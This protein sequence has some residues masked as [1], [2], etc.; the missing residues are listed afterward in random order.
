MRR[1]LSSVAMLMLA[2]WSCPPADAATWDASVD[3]RTRYQSFLD[4]DFN[5]GTHDDRQ[6][7][8]NR[9]YLKATSDLG[10]GLSACLQMQAIFIRNHAPN[11]GGQDFTQADLLQAWL[12]YDMKLGDGRFALRLGRQQLVYGD[13]RLWGHLGWKDVAR[14]F[15]GIKGMYRA[16][17]LNLDLFAVHPADLS[18]MTP[19]PASPHGKALVTWE[20]R[21]LAGAYGTF[22][23]RKETGLDAYFINWRH[24]QRAA[25][26]KGRNIQTFGARAFA[27]WRGFDATVEAAFQRGTWKNG[28]SQ[29][30]SA[31]AAKAGYSLDFWDTR[32]GIEYDFSPG[33]DKTDPTTHRNFVFPFHTNHMHYGEMDF[34]SWANMKDFRIALRTSPVSGLTLT[35][36]V[37]FLFLDKARGD[38]LNVVGTGAVFPGSPGFVQTRAGTEIDLKAIYKTPRMPGLTLVAQ[39]A[40]F[41]PGAAVAERNGGRADPA[42]FITLFA[43]YVS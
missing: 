22:L 15:D 29:N 34:F 10:H 11:H 24:N 40:L 27:R 3:F 18:Q 14:T 42:R 32:I 19:S 35:G 20:N 30:A 23:I 31:F 8:D 41:K 21:T 43:R 9:L 16:G 38:W 13:Q 28:V 33:D 26:G 5:S 6:E 17:R 12:Q 2:M 1:P 4:Y 37:H 39:Y 7:I 25:V 36:N